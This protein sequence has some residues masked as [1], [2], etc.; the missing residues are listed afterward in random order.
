MADFNV[1]DWLVG[2]HVREGRGASIAV[3]HE[4]V[5]TTFEELRDVVARVAGALLGLGVRPGDRV[6]MVM[7]DSLDMASVFLDATRVGAVPVLV[8]PMLP[9]RDVVTVAAAAGARV[10][11]VSG[12]KADAIDELLDGVPDLVHVLATGDAASA[13]IAGVEVARLAAVVADA[14]GVGPRFGSGEEPAFPLCTGGTTG[15]VEAGAPPD[16]SPPH[17]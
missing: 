11:V 6:L 9:A 10:A 14:A 4:G 1:T 13:E 12:E 2:R 8:N 15:R 16:R 17:L 5:A 3:R 7:F